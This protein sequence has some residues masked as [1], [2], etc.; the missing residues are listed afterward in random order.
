[1]FNLVE[2]L[3][4]PPTNSV[5]SNTNPLLSAT[6]GITARKMED[7]QSGQQVKRA[8]GWRKQVITKTTVV[9]DGGEEARVD[10][11]YFDHGNS[12]YWKFLFR[13]CILDQL[14]K[15]LD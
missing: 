4:Q 10:V 8:A 7:L 14:I 6:K 12:G 2:S 15:K 1:M 13:M 11:Y 9:L 3:P 5:G